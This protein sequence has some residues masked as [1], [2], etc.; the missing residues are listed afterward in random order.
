MGLETVLKDTGKW[1]LK[2]RVNNTWRG[3][4]WYIAD[5]LEEAGKWKK[6]LNHVVLT[7]GFYIR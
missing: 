4:L 5:A 1:I 6:Y 2:A 3:R 7:H